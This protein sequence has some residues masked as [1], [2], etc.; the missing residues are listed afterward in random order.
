MVNS[1]FPAILLLA[2]GTT[3]CS[4]QETARR[5]PTTPPAAATEAATVPATTSAP[6]AAA[7][8]PT[9]SAAVVPEASRAQPLRLSFPDASRPIRRAS[10]SVIS[11]NNDTAIGPTQ[12]AEP[13][14]SRELEG[15]VPTQVF[16][17]RADQDT[18]L[19]G[20]GGTT[21]WVPAQAFR[22]PDG[23]PLVAGPVEISLREFYSLADIVLNRLSTRSG[24]QLLETAGMLHLAA[25][26]QGQACALRDSTRLLLSFPTRQEKPGMQ[27]FR[28]VGSP[29]QGLDWQMPMPPTRFIQE[30]VKPP[31]FK[32]GQS[33]A[34]R[35]IASRIKISQEL[36]QRLHRMRITRAERQELRRISGNTGLRVRAVAHAQFTISPGGQV[37]GPSV[38]GISVAE[39]APLVEAAL[40]AMPRWEPARYQGVV[41]PCIYRLTV[42][43][44]AT[45]QAVIRYED[46]D[47]EKTLQQLSAK[48]FVQA[49]EQ[50]AT[51][52]SVAQ[53]SAATV[54]TYLFSAAALGWI[55]CDRFLNSGQPLVTFAVHSGGDKAEVSLVFTNRRSVLRGQIKG[56][57]T[58]FY[59]VP[60]QE[61]VTVVAV[62][63]VG[64]TTLLATQATTLSPRTEENLVFRPVS[65]TGLK[66]EIG[67]LEQTK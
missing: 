37:L 14:V 58:I 66:E 55:N 10:Q 51:D 57:Q 67:R 11:P 53:L 12:A 25:R 5:E 16:T 35:E 63:R 36:Q 59:N 7:V 9:A 52:T 50:Q 49:F 29:E 20:T 39:V 3:A 8:L 43:V 62:K 61:P 48:S 31:R 15:Q 33:I 1:Y 19:R 17:V 44:T 30:L 56:Q 28:G 41:V 13:A 34:R 42:L 2:L 32:R 38:T 21:I 45:G 22:R 47:Q 26:A 27:L 23:S 64:G 60:A 6:V 40:T 54:G 65:L 18:V 24:E 4:Q 46:I